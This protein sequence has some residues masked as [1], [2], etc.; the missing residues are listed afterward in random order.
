MSGAVDVSGR[1]ITVEANG[2]KHR[3]LMYGEGAQRDLLLIPGIT[4]PAVCADFIAKEIAAF[5]YRVVVPDVRGRGETDTAPSGAYRLED[6]AADVAGLV[7]ALGLRRPVLMGHSMGARI[8][9]AYAANIP[10]GSCG[11]LILVEPPVC[12]PGRGMYPTTRK[13]FLEQLHEAQAGTDMEEVRRFYPGWPDRELRIRAEVLASCDETAVLESHEGFENEDFFAYYG[14]LTVPAVLIRGADSPVLPLEAARE[15]ALLQPRIPIVSVP[16]A[17][18]MVP[19][20]NF[21]G[22]IDAV[23][24]HLQIYATDSAELSTYEPQ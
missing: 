19:W 17:G 8:V 20:D 14:R 4:S 23:R 24:P 13:Q 12:G 9:A 1:S 2:L 21:G 11:P 3:V 10:A 22:F 5:G 18:H 16:R 15:L 7:G 6:Y